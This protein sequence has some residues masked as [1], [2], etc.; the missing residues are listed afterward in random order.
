MSK[1][2]LSLLSIAL[3]AMLAP[4]MPLAAQNLL[5]NGDFASGSGNSPD[6][7]TPESWVSSPDTRYRWIAPFDNNPG[8]L[9]VETTDTVNDARWE[10]TVHLDPGWYH[11]HAEAKSENVGAGPGFAGATIGILEFGTRFDQLKGNSDWTELGFYLYVAEPSDVRV[12]LR[13]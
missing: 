3:W 2:K 12:V 11:V 7:W 13:L 6:A 1:F 5:V 9:E 10:Q 8:E 4:S